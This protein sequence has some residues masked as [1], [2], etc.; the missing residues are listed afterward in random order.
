MK[1]LAVI[2]TL[3]L[4][5]FS[6]FA[7]KPKP[8]KTPANQVAQNLVNENEE[9][10]KAVALTD[11]PERIAALRKFVE[12]F[13]ASKEMLRASELL[14][15]TR[16][17]LG[18]EKLQAGETEKG[19]ELFKLAVSDAP[20]PVSDKL[21]TEVVSQ[22]PTNLFFRG[23]RPAA[24]EIAKLVEEKADGNAKQT[25]ALATFYLGMENADE[26]KRLAE[27]AIQI[28]P[29]LPAAYQT[30]GI[31]DRL[32]FQLE[33]AVAAY[34]KA[35]EL[36]ADSAVSKRNLAEM[37][38]AV[39]KPSE[40][41]ALYREVLAKDETDAAARTGLI[42]AL[43]DADK[44]AEA[45]GEMQKSLEQNPNNLFLLVGAAYWYAAKGDG[46][47]AIELAEKAVA[48][49]PRYTW[50]HIALARGL[51]LQKRPFEAEKAMLAA[52]QYGN[53]PTLDYELAAARLAAGFYREAAEVL[54]K[55]FTI[56]DGSI[57]T[58][59]GGRVDAEA[60]DFVELLALERRAGI[61]ET[62][63]ADNAENAARLKSLLDFYQKLETSKDDAAIAQAAD[64]FIKGDDKLK[65][66]RQLFAAARMLEKKS[67]LPKVLDL[68][69]AA[70]GGIDA[71]LDVPNPSAAVL[72]DELYDSRQIAMSR[73]E[74]IIVPDVSRSTL[75]NILRG[76]IEDTAGWALFQEG[77][78]DEAVVRLKRAVSIL[79]EKSSW[80]RNS[81]WRLGTALEADGK[82]KDALDAYIKSYKSSEADA[83]KYGVVE[84]LYQKVNGNTDGLEAK[85]GAKPASIAANFP[86]QT[87]PPVAPKTASETPE[88]APTPEAKT[89][90]NPVP[91]ADVEPSPAPE[92]K[93]ET[94]VETKQTKTETKIEP[95]PAET[96]IEIKTETKT[97]T[98]VETK[99]ETKPETQTE[100]KETMKT[101]A[102]GDTPKSLFEP[103][104][105]TVPKTESPKKPPVENKEI[106]PPKAETK[107]AEAIQNKKP[108]DENGET[109][110]R[111]VIENRIEPNAPCEIVVNQK[112]ISILNSGGS[113]SIMVGFENDGETKEIRA[114][115]SSPN[116]IEVTSEPEIGASSNKA[117]FVIKS[118][119]RK[120]G[121]FTVTFEAACG[122]KEITVKVR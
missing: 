26:A 85:I 55:D 74:L 44:R 69:K 82:S 97:E 70:I 29:N 104:I 51:L 46:A 93:T 115:S 81:M 73:G 98:P 87:E 47:K 122:K 111:V 42:L 64:E 83:V 119:S 32:N 10:E 48:V 110:P 18:D 39:G 102:P 16:A 90:E 80:W 13:P 5:S 117:F 72:A 30:L 4:F 12:D 15:S 11:L 121:E 34:Q 24:V 56:K 100:P 8:T 61:F 37:K 60:K 89:E 7:Q 118:I 114:A 107:A 79:P 28:E 36:D 59:L 78:S 45:E 75:S 27:K 25:L 77:K 6:A 120:T 54:R 35:L 71:G 52:R 106:E 3:V 96:P 116:D 49:E 91:A 31:A 68:T 94:P 65:F 109:R 66:H 57:Q 58:K 20:K 22:I 17:A 86:V 40:A 23:E 63:S 95:K 9:L 101:P 92:T 67:N 62:S 113:L 19:I 76:R 99:T 103:V 105:I 14:V 112:T 41:V 33:D 84:S 2:F 43:F 53:F 38:R 1:N 50:A 108:S 21:F 88:T